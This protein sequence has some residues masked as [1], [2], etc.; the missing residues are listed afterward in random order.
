MLMKMY[1]CAVRHL[2]KGECNVPS[3]GWFKVEEQTWLV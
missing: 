1:I 2:K 3:P